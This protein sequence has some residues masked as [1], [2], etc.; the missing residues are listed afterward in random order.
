MP[1]PD[2]T[3][4]AVA[5]SLTVA[6]VLFAALATWSLAAR[7]TIPISLDGTVTSIETR[8]EK[9]PGVDDVW[10]VTVDDKQRHL[11]ATIADRLE[12]GDRVFKQ[13]WDTRLDVNNESRTVNLS[14]DARAMVL[15][16][17]LMALV[18]AALALPRRRT[19]AS[20]TAR[21]PEKS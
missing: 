6:A 20:A 21:P 11:D 19:R 16:A 2:A 15:L 7:S 14:G 13:R 1:S 9:H 18:A 10:M 3:R 12:I 5:A 17:P 8:A 4:R